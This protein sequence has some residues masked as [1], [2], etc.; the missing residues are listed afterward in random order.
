LGKEGKYFSVI[1]KSCMFDARAAAI[2]VADQ[3]GI[4]YST[5][6]RKPI[7]TVKDPLE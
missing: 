4:K 1:E 5:K 7:K 6:I 2:R 3:L